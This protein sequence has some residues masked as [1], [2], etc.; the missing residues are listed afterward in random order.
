VSWTRNQ[1]V[2]LC[3]EIEAICPAF[4]CHVALTGGCLYKDG[5]RKDLDVLF[6]RIRQVAEIDQ[7]GLFE[8]LRAI[9][10]EHVAD[11]GW[12]NKATYRGHKIDCF[13]PECPSG[14][15]SSDVEKLPSVVLRDNAD[16]MAF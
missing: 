15:Y 11:Y 10:I 3:R 6:Y 1:A 8:A 13:F 5:A 12:C 9:G 4:G 16:E 7:D 14:D 2:A